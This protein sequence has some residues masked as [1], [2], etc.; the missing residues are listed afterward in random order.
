MNRKKVLGLLAILLVVASIG[1]VAAFGGKYSVMDPQGR[2][3]I[4]NAIKANDYN[5]W[6]EAITSQLTEENFNKTVQ[7]YQAMSRRHGNMSEKRELMFSGN[8]AL[9]TEMIQ[10]IKDGNYEAWNTAAVNSNSPLVSKIA[11]ED[12]F[13]ILVQLYQAKQDGNFTKVK[14][15]SLQ[16]GLPAGNGRHKMPGHFGR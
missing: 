1:S 12:Q 3:E 10:A 7:G 9:N 4:L 16:L 15:L 5:A 8:Q 14:E 6:K 13:K 11:T 2:D